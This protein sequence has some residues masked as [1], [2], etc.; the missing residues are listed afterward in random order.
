MDK[1]EE[2]G[3]CGMPLDDDE[4]QYCL[5][6]ELNMLREIAAEASVNEN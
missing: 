1:Y 5:G 4:I 2:C 3:L 6:C